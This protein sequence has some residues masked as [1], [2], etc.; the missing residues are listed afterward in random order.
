MVVVGVD[1]E[2]GR[3]GEEGERDDGRPLGG[4]GERDKGSL[5]AA[6][7][8]LSL[9]L[10]L[11]SCRLQICLLPFS[12]ASLLNFLRDDAV[13]VILSSHHSVSLYVS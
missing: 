3:R 1:D 11:I 4:R 10:A 2:Q 9:R 8:G 5:P 7:S 12:A 13:T 6:F